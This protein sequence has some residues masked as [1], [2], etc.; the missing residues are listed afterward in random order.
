MG[1]YTSS[2]CTHSRGLWSH[3]I[4]SLSPERYEAARP[5]LML[6]KTRVNLKRLPSCPRPRTLGGRTEEHRS[7]PYLHDT[8]TDGRQ[9]LLDDHT[10]D[11]NGHSGREGGRNTTKVNVL[12]GNTSRNATKCAEGVQGRQRNATYSSTQKYGPVR[13]ISQQCDLG[14]RSVVPQS[15]LIGR[16]DVSSFELRSQKY[17]RDS[18]LDESS[19]SR[20]TKLNLGAS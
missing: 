19:A 5:M 16:L 15:P 2:P 12:R 14:R 8:R 18:V 3:V 13:E 4:G 9:D 20:S 10:M 7:C 6:P 17:G 1:L 11:E